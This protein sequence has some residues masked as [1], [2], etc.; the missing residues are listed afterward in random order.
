MIHACLQRI[1]DKDV[2]GLILVCDVT[3]GCFALF[4]LIAMRV[5]T[6]R[7]EAEGARRVGCARCA[8]CHDEGEGGGTNAWNAV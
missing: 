5:S 7:L 3:S 2:F 8:V 6:M 4:V 1:C